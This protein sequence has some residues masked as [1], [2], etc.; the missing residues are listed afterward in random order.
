[1]MPNEN[2]SFFFFFEQRKLISVISMLKQYIYSF[3]N[4]QFKRLKKVSHH[5]YI[6]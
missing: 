5:M 4:K 1:M 6:R 3:G 2:S